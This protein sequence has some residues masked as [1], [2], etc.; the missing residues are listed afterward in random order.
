MS[1]NDAEVYRI[2]K[3]SSKWIIF[4]V[5]SPI[6]YMLVAH[7]VMFVDSS[8]IALDTLIW[9]A[10]GLLGIVMLVWWF[11]ALR[12]IMLVASM[13]NRANRDL[14]ETVKN[15]SIIKDE[16]KELKDIVSK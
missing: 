9:C 10:A 6:V 13:T 16:V 14:T 2:I 15:V 8:Q 12:T 4:G 5:L 11:W 1:D 3:Q 7:V